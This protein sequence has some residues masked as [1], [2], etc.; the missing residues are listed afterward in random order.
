MIKAIIFDFYGVVCGKGIWET[1]RLAGGDLD[2]HTDVLEELV[3]KEAVNAI[4]A[5][6]FHG[7]FAERAG[8]SL[9]QW[10]KFSQ[11][12]DDLNADTLELIKSLKGKYKIALVSNSRKGV[13]EAKLG[14]SIKL[15]DNVVVSG[16]LGFAKPDPKIFKYVAE[17]LGVDPEQCVFTDDHQQY[18]DGAERAGMRAIH[19]KSAAQF[20]DDLT[21]IILSQAKGKS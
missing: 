19:F 7:G 2:K 3:D 16:N 1:F 20:S 10:H 13:V 11:D 8:M 21:K 9:E 14:E 5:D 17:Q 15:F 4:T 18:L 6:E 12:H